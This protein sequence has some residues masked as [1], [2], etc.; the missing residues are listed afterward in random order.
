MSIIKKQHIFLPK[1]HLDYSKWSV[2]A[3]GQFSSEPEYWEKLSEYVGGNPSTLDLV[4]PEIYFGRDNFERIKNINKTM[5]SYYESGLLEDAGPCMIL[6]NRSTKN[7]PKRLGIMVAVDLESFDYKANAN[8]L[9][10]A[11]EGTIVEKIPPR[12]EIRRDAI[13][14]LP[15][16]MLLYDDREQN[17]AENLFKNR[18]NLEQVYDFD[19]NMEGGHLSGWK[20]KDVDEVIGKFD[21]LLKPEYIEKTFNTK[22]PLLF[23]VGDGNHSLATAKAHWNNVKN[24]ISEEE[25]LV[26]PARFALVEVVNIHD[27]GIDFNPIYRV[28]RNPDRRFVKDLLNLSKINVNKA[29]KDSYLTETIF[30]SG[31]E[32]PLYLPNNSPLAIKMVQ[33]YIEKEVSEQLEMSVDYV[34]GLE[35]LKAICEKDKKAIGITLPTLNKNELFEFV[36][37]HGILPRK[38]FSLGEAREKRYYLEAHKIKLI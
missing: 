13:F 34:H 9:I 26:H 36:I 23:A 4:L 27:E 3:C 25:K 37:K 17:I 15:H 19:L 38:A 5:R 31:E 32:V 33:E 8:T 22:T 35:S 28:V 2:I 29:E 6:L 24:F 7:N 30:M 12:L 14:E 1:K 21:E 11:T 18:E 16:A 10:R 20:I